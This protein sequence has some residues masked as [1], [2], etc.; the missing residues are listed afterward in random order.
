[1]R[2]LFRNMRGLLHKV[3]KVT[4]ILSFYALTLIVWAYILPA[5]AAAILALFLVVACAMRWGLIGGTVSALWST[6]AMLFSFYSPQYSTTRSLILGSLAY[7]IIG[8]GLGK[9]I[10]IIRSQQLQLQEG[11]NRYRSLFER[12]KDAI[13]LVDTE[14]CIRDCNP[15]ACALLG[16]NRE[17]M[18]TKNLRD[19][20]PTEDLAAESLKIGQVLEGKPISV[21]RKLRRKDGTVVIVEA[22][23]SKLESKMILGIAHNITKRKENEI[24]IREQLQTLSTLYTGAQKLSES[25]DLKMLA[26]EITRTCVEDF[27]ASLSWLGHAEPDGQVKILFQYPKEHPYPRDIAVRWDD[28]PQ[29]QGPTGRAIRSGTPQITED[30]TTDFRFVPWRETALLKAGFCTS[31]ALPLVS[32]GYIF[33]AISLYSDKLG[34]FSPKRLEMFQAFVHQAASALENARLF[35]ETQRRLLHIQ[36]LRNI[37]M[38]ITGSLDP[39]VTF[40]VALDEVTRQ[41]DIDAASILYLNPY[42][43]T[44]RYAAGR[45]FYNRNIEKTSLRLGKGIAGRAALEK[46]TVYIPN[47]SESSEFTRTGLFATENFTAYY[48]VPLIAKGRVLGV[49]EIFHRLPHEGNSEWLEF[50]ET[51]A[52][53]IAIAIDN[54]ELF[55]N[56][57]RSKTEITQAYDATIEALSYALDLK[58]KETEGHSRRVTELTLRIAREMGIKEEDLVH[59]RR[60]ALLHDIGK[61]GIPDDILIKPGKLTDDEWEIMRKHPIHAYQMLSRIEYLRPALDIPYCHHEKWDGTGYPRGLKGEEIPLAARIFAVVDVMDA[62]TNDRPYRKAWPMEKALEYFR[63]QSGKHFDPRVVEVFLSLVERN[64]LFEEEE[65]S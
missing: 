43:Q 55:H 19:L 48:A 58:D 57:E 41:L 59:I 54:T 20:I 37:D 28:T 44:L 29:G 46:R 45:G 26:H 2:V 1:M 36:A 21:E 42:T 18:L 6:G 53:Q 56:L 60:G 27:G 5:V 31:A 49:L 34:F 40:S 33:G 12:G 50:L 8:I 15:A 61:M 14:G 11:G 17:E 47:L 22:S 25:L 24:Q 4:L 64:L 65:G 32:R 39:R 3:D 9:V 23:L 63:E 62:L 10:D 13:L 30:I 7:F 52:G 38:A 51:L 35:E 16:Y